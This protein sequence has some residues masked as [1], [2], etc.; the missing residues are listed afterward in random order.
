MP[1]R[2]GGEKGW[3]SFPRALRFSVDGTGYSYYDE[4]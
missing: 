1:K 4:P 3:Q 2:R